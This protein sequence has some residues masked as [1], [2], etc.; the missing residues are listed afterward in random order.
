MKLYN[1]P[2]EMQL[3]FLAPVKIKTSRAMRNI[4]NY[5]KEQTN[6]KNYLISD[7]LEY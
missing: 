3:N 4:Y 1:R 7:H 6:V 2:P 5:N